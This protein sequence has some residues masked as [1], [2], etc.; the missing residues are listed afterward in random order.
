MNKDEGTLDSVTE[1]QI[2]VSEGLSHKLLGRAAVHLYPVLKRRIALPAV[3]V[4]LSEVSPAGNPRSG[5][6]ALI[7]HFAASAILDPNLVKADLF[8]R[9]LAMDIAVALTH[10][11]WGLPISMANLSH[12]G[13]GVLKPDLEG[14]LIWSVYWTHEFYLGRQEWPFPDDNRNLYVG[15]TAGNY[16]PDE[17]LPIEDEQQHEF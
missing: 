11:N 17:Y 16:P 10:E 9:E 13:P 12:V 2:K 6:T 15:I 3:I 8:V 14:Y 4:E 1:L 7:G 5:V